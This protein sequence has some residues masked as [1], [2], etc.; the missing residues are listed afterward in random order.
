MTSTPTLP[1]PSPQVLE[2]LVR[3]G[4]ITP[5]TSMAD[6]LASWLS[7]PSGTA[8]V[9]ARHAA[10]GGAS[11]LRAHPVLPPA[12]AARI[13]MSEVREARQAWLQTLASRDASAAAELYHPRGAR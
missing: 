7:D 5:V 6:E 9:A 2:Q 11:P 8:T 4:S 3:T 10:G 13:T 1:P 12:T